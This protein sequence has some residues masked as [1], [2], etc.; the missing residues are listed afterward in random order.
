MRNHIAQQRNQAIG[1]NFCKVARL[2][3]CLCRTRFWQIVACGK[4]RQKVTKGQGKCMALLPVRFM[5]SILD[6][7]DAFVR[8]IIQGD[9]YLSRLPI[10][11]E[12][13]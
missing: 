7:W 13:R 11:L 6:G 5:V 8:N 4:I 10:K 12:I 3:S 1:W 2:L 9:S